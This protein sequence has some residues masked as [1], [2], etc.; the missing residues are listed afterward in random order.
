[1]S[2]FE[3]VQWTVA[4]SVSGCSGRPLAMARRGVAETVEGFE[5]QDFVRFGIGGDDFFDGKNFHGAASADIGSDQIL[6]VRLIEADGLGG[7]REKID[8]GRTAEAERVRGNVELESLL[9]LAAFEA[10][11]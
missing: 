7:M 1:M 8:G 11:D 5:F 4:E 9:A 6:R 10:G 2:R 3:Q